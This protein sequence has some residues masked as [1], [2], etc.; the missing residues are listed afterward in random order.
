MRAKAEDR[1]KKLEEFANFVIE[2]LKTQETID[3]RA[4]LKIEAEFE[5]SKIFILSSF[6]PAEIDMN[7]EIIQEI[8]LIEAKLNTALE[9]ARSKHQTRIEQERASILRE[10]VT[11]VSRLIEKLRLS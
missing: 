3:E 10:I 9:L 11:M 5:K 4:L 7:P 8:S 2:R 6:T 1:I